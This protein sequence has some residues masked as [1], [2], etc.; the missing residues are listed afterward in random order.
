MSQ[1]TEKDPKREGDDPPL[2]WADITGM[3]VIIVVAIITLVA[4]L[5]FSYIIAL[6]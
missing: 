5:F 1:R 6:S 4:L 2:A 3:G